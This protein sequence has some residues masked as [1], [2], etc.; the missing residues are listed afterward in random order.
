MKKVYFDRL[1]L[2]ELI[3]DTINLYK[4]N[5]LSEKAAINVLTRCIE[6]KV[7]KELRNEKNQ[8]RDN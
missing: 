6:D 3:K 2:T 4:A 1:V 7:R 8:E 5:K